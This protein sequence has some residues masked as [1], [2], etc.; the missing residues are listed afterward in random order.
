[1]K[2]YF[3]RHGDYQN[4]ENVVPFCLPGFP[5]S[6]LGKSQIQQVAVKLS[7]IRFRAI[8]TSPITRCLESAAIIA[9]TLH[10]FPNPKNEI[11]ETRTPLQGTKRSEF[12]AD[13]YVEPQHIEG[14]GETK[15][16]IIE[17]MAQFVGELK[18]TSKNSVYLIV[19]HGD[20]MMFYFQHV[21]KRE[22]RYIPMGG[23]VVLDYTQTGIPKYTELI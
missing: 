14:G 20:P 23:L 7:H 9:E 22:V 2:I 19:S 4:P 12:P 16:E 5:L 17:R 13:I 15:L 8:F 21:L 11:I 6:E 10:L 3:A 18:L 1:M